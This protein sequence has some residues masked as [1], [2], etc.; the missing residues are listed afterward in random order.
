MWTYTYPLQGLLSSL[1][2]S[3]SDEIRSCKNS[4]LHLCFVFKLREFG[5]NDAEYDILMA[6]EV[7]ERFKAP[8]AKRIIFQKIGRDIQRLKEFD[9]D[10]IIASF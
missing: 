10:A 3:F 4:F 5:R 1:L 6:G 7:K 8:R 9:S 2:C